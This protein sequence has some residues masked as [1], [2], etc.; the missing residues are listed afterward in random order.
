M[1]NEVKSLQSVSQHVPPPPPVTARSAAASDSGKQV[2][3]TGETEPRQ[4]PPSE[5]EVRKAA[6][7]LA[8]FASS[9]G[10]NLRFEVDDDSGMTLIK[11]I[12]P[13]TDEVVRQIPSEE[14]VDRARQVSDGGDMRLLDELV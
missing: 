5:T 3:P 7:M 10:R 14:A 6:E 4:A 8:E 13:E 9:I 11:V 2:P 12:D 1:A